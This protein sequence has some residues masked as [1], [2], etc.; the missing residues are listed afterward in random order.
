MYN[1]EELTV[2]RVHSVRDGMMVY[3]KYPTWKYEFAFLIQSDGKVKGRTATGF[4]EE[5]SSE[6]ARVI[7]AKVKNRSIYLA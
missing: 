1:I 7:Y 2:S 4:W 3:A 6:I 5:V